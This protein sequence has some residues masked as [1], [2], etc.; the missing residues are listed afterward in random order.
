MIGDDKGA[1]MENALAIQTE[2]RK[3]L[4]EAMSVAYT[5]GADLYFNDVCQLIEIGPVAIKPM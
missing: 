2:N 1:A 4:I 5:D 3:I